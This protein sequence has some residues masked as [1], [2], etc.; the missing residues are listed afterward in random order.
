M[1]MTDRELKAFSS[2]K[3]QWMQEVQ[4]WEI[5][6]WL[7]LQMDPACTGTRQWLQR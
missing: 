1:E 5:P 3:L 6:T 2:R 7:M 4:E